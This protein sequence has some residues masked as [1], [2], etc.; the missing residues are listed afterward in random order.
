M[1]TF[2]VNECTGKMENFDVLYS[3]NA[4]EEA[5]PLIGAGVLAQSTDYLT[6][7]DISISSD[8]GYVNR[9]FSTQ[10]KSAALNAPRYTENPLS[11]TDSDISI[12]DFLDIVN[13]HFPDILPESVLGHYGHTSRLD[14][15]LGE[16]AM[17]SMEEDISDE[18]REFA[19]IQLKIRDKL[20]QG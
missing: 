1:V 16:S 3:M 10:K 19:E 5:A 9:S 20:L 8:L 4:K 6:A 7:S 12:A 11:I 14:G 13:R 15:N 17:C 2:V 18:Q